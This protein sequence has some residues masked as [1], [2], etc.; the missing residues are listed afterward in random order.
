MP[1]SPE[2]EILN[3]L[4]DEQEKFEIS[5]DQEPKVSREVDSL[6]E[7]VEKDISL[8]KP[9]NDDAGQPLVSHMPVL[10][11]PPL[12]VLPLTKTKYFS[13]V[14]QTVENSIVWLKEWCGR[15]IKI[16]G[17]RTSFAEEKE[18]GNK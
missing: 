14:K 5:S 17:E 8:V 16:F 6:I 3:Q 10:T 15:L 4:F 1:D 13:K 18:D 2:K 7:K 12:I 9:I 11:P